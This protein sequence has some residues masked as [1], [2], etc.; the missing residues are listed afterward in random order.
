MPILLSRLCVLLMVFASSKGEDFASVFK[1]RIQNPINVEYR[2]V[3]ESHVDGK[4]TGKTSCLVEMVSEPTKSAEV[5]L[6]FKNFLSLK[7]DSD[8]SPAEIKIVILLDTETGVPSLKKNDS[9]VGKL[10]PSGRQI[11]ASIIAEAICSTPRFNGSKASSEAYFPVV[12][13]GITSV[14][15]IRFMNIK[16]LLYFM[17]FEADSHDGDSVAAG[18]GQSWEGGSLVDS[19]DGWPIAIS[20]F[21]E[22]ATPEGVSITRLTVNRLK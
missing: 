18:I 10:R 16:G 19:R 14:S 4:I 3:F 15:P 9:P 21:I 13:T 8:Q 11:M 2:A 20:W 12:V 1:S 6:T 17:K 5:I 7:E 22:P